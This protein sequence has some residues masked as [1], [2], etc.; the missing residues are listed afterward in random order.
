MRA[1]D[2]S[3]ARWREIKRVLARV[4]VDAESV[5]IDERPLRVELDRLAG[6]YAEASQQK[7]PTT[8]QLQHIVRRPRRSC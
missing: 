5:Q 6:Q 4:G 8:K 7:I 3:N 2:D 1:P